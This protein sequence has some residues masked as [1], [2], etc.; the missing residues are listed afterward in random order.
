[1]GW[2]HVNVKFYPY[3][4]GGEGETSFSHA[5]GRPQKVLGYFLR[6][7]KGGGGSTLLNGG[8]E[9]FYPVLRGGAKSF[10]PAIFP[11]CSPPLPCGHVCVSM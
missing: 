3:E 7:R 6:G 5:K 2:G 11:F 4:K 9:K 8:C 1:M 10:G